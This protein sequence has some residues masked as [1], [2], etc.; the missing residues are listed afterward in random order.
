MDQLIAPQMTQRTAA[1]VYENLVP[2]REPVLRQGRLNAK[3]TVPSLLVDEGHTSSTELYRPWQSIGARGTNTISSKLA[4][5][6]LP[7]TRKFY[8][9]RLEEDVRQQ[10]E[11]QELL[12]ETE[13]ALVRLEDMIL[14][15]IERLGVRSISYEVFRHLVVAGNVLIHVSKSGTRLFPLHQFVC[16]RDH[17][18]NL[19]EIVILEQVTPDE[20]PTEVLS[21]P[22][23]L[24]D[25]KSRE[26]SCKVYTHVYREGKRWHSYQE[27]NGHRFNEVHYGKRRCPYLPL[28]YT[29]IDGEAYGRA[30]IE[31]YFGDLCASEMLS[32]AIIQFSAAAAKIVGGIRPGSVADPDDLTRAESGQF[33]FFE[34]DDVFFLTMEKFNDFSVAKS[35]LD[36][37]NNRLAY[38]FLL[39]SAIQREGERVTAEEIR[40]MA[41]ELEDALGGIYTL[42]SNEYQ[43]AIVEI[44]LD[45]LRSRGLV[46]LPDKTVRPSIT[47]GIDALGRSHELARLDAL[48]GGAVQTFGPE[49]VRNFNVSEYLRRRVAALDLDPTKLIRSEE[50]LAQEQQQA[51]AA[52]AV[53]KLGPSVIKAGADQMKPT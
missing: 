36:D 25:E 4:V 45:L 29:R 43:L 50:E 37:I 41:Q 6:L 17:E 30:L 22:M 53:N 16:R 27:Y 12:T 49:V 1:G 52:E 39:N 46:S 2:L 15:E 23:T 35:T 28:R 33:H 26:K 10:F 18:G 38:V 20:L 51:M 19:L 3:L 8:R 21:D 40:T 47:T 34:K 31:E 24:A 9:L 32:K 48:V 7:P 42:L 5:T 11:N 13:Q 44:V 14:R